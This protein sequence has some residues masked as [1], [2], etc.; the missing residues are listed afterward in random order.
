M[1]KIQ[2]KKLVNIFTHCGRAVLKWVYWQN[3]SAASVHEQC[4]LPAQLECTSQY[5][6]S[7]FPTPI[8]VYG[9]NIPGQYMHMSGTFPVDMGNCNEKRVF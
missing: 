6:Y 5:V 2:Y 3:Q 1:I 8:Y 4:N 7:K 9:W